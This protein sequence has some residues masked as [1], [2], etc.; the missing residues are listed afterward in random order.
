MARMIAAK[1]LVVRGCRDI[2]C[3]ARCP[4]ACGSAV[5]LQPPLRPGDALIGGLAAGAA[6]L[7]S[8]PERAGARPDLLPGFDRRPTGRCGGE[9]DNHPC[10]PRDR[11][12]FQPLTH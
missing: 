11:I 7:D 6:R 1:E 5:P 12:V 4:A 10:C 9:C 2:S 8:L 3:R